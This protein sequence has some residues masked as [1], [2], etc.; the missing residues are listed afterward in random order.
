MPDTGAMTSTV[1]NQLPPR[2]TTSHRW[3][4]KWATLGGRGTP[5]IPISSPTINN[6]E[7]TEKT[8][9]H[10]I[11]GNSHQQ[12]QQRYSTSL[13]RKSST[14]SRTN[15]NE[16]INNSN[17]NTETPSLKKSRSLIN[18]LR[19][20]L[21]SPAVLRRFRTKSRENSKQ[22]ITEINHDN[23]IHND[24]HNYYHD[25]KISTQLIND[26]N[27]NNNNNKK[28][29]KRDPSPMKRF[30][31]R[32][33][34]LTRS[35]THTSIDNEQHTR[36]SSSPSIIHNKDQVDHIN[37]CYDE[38]RAKYFDNNNNNTN[39]K[40]NTLSH[41]PQQQQQQQNSNIIQPLINDRFKDILST[42]TASSI[43]YY[44]RQTNDIHN[45]SLSTISMN[46]SLLSHDFLNNSQ[47]VIQLS[48]TITSDDPLLQARKQ[49]NI[50]L[51]CMLSGY[52]FTTPFGN[53]EKLLGQHDIF[54]FHHYHDVGKRKFDFNFTNNNN[55]NN[56]MYSSLR[57]R[58]MSRSID[59]FRRATT[60]I[61][62]E[63]IPTTNP[64]V[65]S[66][67]NLLD[68]DE[69]SSNMPIEN[70]LI[71]RED[72]DIIESEP[73]VYSSKVH[74]T[75][76]VSLHVK[77]FISS[78]SNN[79]DKNIDLINEKL[80][81]ENN[82]EFE[83]NFLR[84]VDRALGVVNHDDNH[85]LQAVYDIP[86]NT[87]NSN[88]NLMEITERALSTFNNTNIFMDNEPKYE[89]INDEHRI[90]GAESPN[91]ELF[92]RTG[93]LFDTEIVHWQSSAVY[94]HQPTIINHE[95]NNCNDENSIDDHVWSIVDD[96]TQK[97]HEFLLDEPQN[98]QQFLTLLDNEE[99][100]IK[101]KA[102]SYNKLLQTDD[103]RLN[104]DVR[105]DINAVIGEVNLLLKGKLKQF[106]G[107]CQ[108]N[109]S[110]SNTSA[111]EPTPLDSDLEGFWDITYPLI[112]KVKIKFT[113]LDARK[114]KQW[115]SIED[116]YDP[117]D[118]NN[119][120]RII[121][122]RLKQLQPHQNKSKSSTTKPVND[123]LK[124]LIQERRKAAANVSNTANQNHDIEIF[125][126]HK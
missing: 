76:A 53:H 123:D 50:K 100:T 103:S 91:V 26:D 107:L 21:N 85:L 45:R 60:T 44:E 111:G 124:K 7:F 81:D 16:I 51:N 116:E 15:G 106:R 22:I 9:G 30:T 49:S 14:I 40:K 18:V 126:T 64:T 56:R 93:E 42:T 90:D 88:M 72:G 41:I 92:D 13:F 27:N 32:L 84:A 104:D 95:Q 83:R 59:S 62:N 31:N 47:Q 69:Y 17:L 89:Q 105:S 122:E 46:G 5:S 65:E 43:E 34:Q 19:S 115:I 36:K 57:T 101:S 98:G 87:N 74:V 113:K 112:D 96:L 97:T 2:T 118:V 55:N 75:P 6:C 70:E 48:P 38:I 25:E 28:L 109:V 68:D 73:K 102:D 4:R 10:H 35:S 108:A 37:A 52:G 3:P 119:R 114:A 79:D 24:N 58:P 82:D 1:S 66:N 33:V 86:M 8:N 54:K 121:D 29:R 125:V 67:N 61:E 94:D 99:K 23:K 63:I 39:I 71:I 80:Y 78:S 11:N 120:P 117:N 110:K 77:T 12:Q 20:K